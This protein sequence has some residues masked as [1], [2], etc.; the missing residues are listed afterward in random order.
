V[1]HGITHPA[2]PLEKPPD[3]A[4]RGRAERIAMVAVREGGEAVALGLA[5]LLISEFLARRL[6]IVMGH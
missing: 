4:K 3:A 2:E 5:G 1:L 6:R